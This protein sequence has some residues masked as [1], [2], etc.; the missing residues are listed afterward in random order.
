MDGGDSL[1]SPI[2][3]IGFNRP[4]L[5]KKAIDT[6]RIIRPEK[7]YVHI[8]GPRDNNKN[9]TLLV[10]K[11]LYEIEQVDWK[12]KIEIRIQEENLGCKKAVIFA[13][14]WAFKHETKL[15]I[16]ED[17][18]KFSASFIDFC[19]N[20]LIRKENNENALL[21]SGY[22]PISSTLPTKLDNQNQIL[23]SSYPMVWGWATWKN[24][25]ESCYDV[26]PNLNLK[27]IVL[28]WQKN[29]FNPIASSYF[30]ISLFLIQRDKLDTW[31]FQ[32]Y[33][34]C[35]INKKNV[36]VPFTSLTNNVGFRSDAT[37]TK[38][39]DLAIPTKFKTKK[40]ID[41]SNFDKLYRKHLRKILTKSIVERVKNLIKNI[42]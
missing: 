27:K 28:I 31:D 18:I 16:I 34:S 10:S 5:L 30:I 12:T 26:H 14:N 9:D 8:D 7:L 1:G 40:N 13:I 3:L 25:W 15:I 2:L 6:L 33:L 11:C 29:K 32:L 19:N 23:L 21:I 35:L 20:Q 24:Q 39:S 38:A 37:H 17:D 4:D 36:I 22:N 42:D 41:S